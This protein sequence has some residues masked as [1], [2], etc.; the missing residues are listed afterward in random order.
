M[1]LRDIT[2][3]LF[4]WG[5]PK[6]ETRDVDRGEVPFEAFVQEL[7]SVNTICLLVQPRRQQF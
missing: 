2:L 7:I 6:D 1:L 3:E 4:A 5:L